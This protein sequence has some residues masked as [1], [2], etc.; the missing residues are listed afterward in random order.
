M[1]DL[2]GTWVRLQEQALAMHKTNIDIVFKNMGNSSFAGAAEAARE[3]ADAQV[4][5]WETWLSLFGPRT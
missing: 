3:V 1:T 5:A 2:F 4:K